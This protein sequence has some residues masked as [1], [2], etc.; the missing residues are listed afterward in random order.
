MSSVRN[1][2]DS[3]SEGV[4]ED[5]GAILTVPRKILAGQGERGREK[6]VEHL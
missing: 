3:S 2:C 1:G 5:E 4:E 6:G